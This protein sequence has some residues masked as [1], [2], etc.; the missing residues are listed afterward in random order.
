MVLE[1]YECI[2]LYIFLKKREGKL[3][4]EL[5]KIMGRCEKYAYE[6]LSALEL[7]GL[8]ELSENSGDRE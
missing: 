5:E 4:V 6:H 8:L 3:P 2:A 1:T 7:E